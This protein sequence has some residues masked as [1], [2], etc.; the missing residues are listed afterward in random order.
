MTNLPTRP[1]DLPLSATLGQLVEAYH[2]HAGRLVDARHGLG[3]PLTA[4]QLAAHAVAAL[5]VQHVLA[6]RVL[7]PR[8]CDVRDALAHGAT[9]DQVAAALG[10]DEDEVAAG[11]TSWVDGQRREDLITDVEHT[12]IVA[13][14]AGWQR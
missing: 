5:A 4:E 10:L 14:V 2:A 7:W 1:A 8:W 12:E 6:E 13:L 9:I 3:E 11:L